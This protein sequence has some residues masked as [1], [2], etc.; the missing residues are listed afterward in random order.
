MYFVQKDKKIDLINTIDVTGQCTSSVR[1]SS[2]DWTDHLAMSSGQAMSSGKIA[3]TVLP[4]GQPGNR[5]PCTRCTHAKMVVNL[6]SGRL[7]P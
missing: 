1:S 6:P 4:T 5:R 7:N 2:I 3:I